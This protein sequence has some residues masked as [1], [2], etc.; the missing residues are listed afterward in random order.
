MAINRLRGSDAASKVIVLVTDG[1]NNRGE[2]DPTTAAS[3]A[4]TL[5]VK[6]YTIGVGTRG[7]VPYPVE[8]PVLG[9]RYI[10]LRADIDEESLQGIAAETGGR[11]FRATDTDSLRTIFAEIDALEK[12]EIR[13]RHYMLYTELFP[14]FAWT[15][16]GIFLVETIL[17]STR[18]RRL[19]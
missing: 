15:G 3:L 14:W 17:S 1:R 2:I 16:L 18:L 4:R 7:E 12:S 11:Y 5:G 10:Y 9:R 19:P 8:D 13:V 6:I